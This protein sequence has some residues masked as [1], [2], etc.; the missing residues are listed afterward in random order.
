M[1]PSADNVMGKKRCKAKSSRTGVQCKQ[2]AIHGGEV[3]ITHGGSAPQVKAAAALRLSGLVDPSIAVLAK[4]LKNDK[5]PELAL[6]AAKDVLD[7]SGLG[8]V[9]KLE[10]VTPADRL[11]SDERRARILQLHAELFAAEGTVQ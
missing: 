5:R 6:N 2:W 10:D 11:T 3:C 8:A 4:T 1:N 7:R 9:H